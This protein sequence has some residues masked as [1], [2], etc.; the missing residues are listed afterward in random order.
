MGRPLRIIQGEYP[1]HV[2][3]RTNN[4]EFRF[5]PKRGV[6]LMFAKIINEAI[7]K[8][9]IEVTHFILMSNHY[10]I[11]FKTPNCNI[12]RAMQYINSRVAREYNKRHNRTG[13]LWQDRYKSII[14]ENDIYLYNIIKYIYFNPVRAGIVSHPKDYVPSTFEFYYNNK[15]IDIFL[16][17]CEFFVALG[18]GEERTRRFRELFESFNEFELTKFRKELKGLFY[19][20][21]RFLILMREK[22]KEK[23]N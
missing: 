11:I 4:K 13:H 1:Y 15:K 14:V 17:E 18:D 9:S 12:H 20:S 10:H 3:T 23:L 7:E 22:Y 16:H 8:Y 2:T 19:G 21:D 5:K 6:F